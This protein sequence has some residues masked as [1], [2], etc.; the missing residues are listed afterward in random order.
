MYSVGIYRPKSDFLPFSIIIG[1]GYAALSVDCTEEEANHFELE[2]L[3]FKIED[4]SSET[5][6]S[7][8]SYYHDCELSPEI[9]LSHIGKYQ[10]SEIPFKDIEAGFQLYPT[11]LNS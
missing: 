2:K 5:N 9:V 7:R 4:N 6:L 8:T 1:T 3:I 10:Y 11:S